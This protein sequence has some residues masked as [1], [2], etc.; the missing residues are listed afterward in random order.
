M[1]ARAADARRL[2]GWLREA[3]RLHKRQ[4]WGEPRVWC[5]ARL[6]AETGR[7]WAQKIEGLLARDA[8]Q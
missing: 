8:K 6:E 4:G 5:C 7:P 3:L 1:T 2:A